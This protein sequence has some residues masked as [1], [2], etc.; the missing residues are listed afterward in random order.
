MA[1]GE[2]DVRIVQIIRRTDTYIINLGS[3]SFQFIKMPVESFEFYKKITFREVTIYPP[4]AV[5]LIKT[6]QEIVACLFYGMKM[7]DGDV[8]GNTYYSEIFWS[9]CHSILLKRCTKILIYS[10]NPA[11]LNLVSLTTFGA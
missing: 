6:C 7:S 8:S 11:I 4:Y 10:R 9:N 5:K 2:S 3:G 1:E